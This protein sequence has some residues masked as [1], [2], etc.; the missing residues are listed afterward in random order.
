[1]FQEYYNILQFLSQFEKKE[2]KKKKEKIHTKNNPAPFQA[3]CFPK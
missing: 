1:M 2:K 3:A